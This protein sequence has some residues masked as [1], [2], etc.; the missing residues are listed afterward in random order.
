MNISSL[1]NAI[2]LGSKQEND[3]SLGQGRQFRILI[4]LTPNRLVLNL[5][6]YRIQVYLV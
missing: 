3:P 5:S 1:M 2:G 6:F 4:E